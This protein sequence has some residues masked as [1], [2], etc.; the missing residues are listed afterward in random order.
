MLT[1]RRYV[2]LFVN[3]KNSFDFCL[4]KLSSHARTIVNILYANKISV[5][6]F[7]YIK[8]HLHNQNSFPYHNHYHQIQRA[9]ELGSRFKT[10]AFAEVFQGLIAELSV[11]WDINY[12]DS[13][14]CMKLGIKVS[15]NCFF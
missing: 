12:F 2:C 1:I 11:S 5:L 6:T 9:E 3:L 4:K 10:D 15:L 7:K 14:S 13:Y 8:H